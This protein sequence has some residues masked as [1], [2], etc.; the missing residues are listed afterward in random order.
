M[1]DESGALE[2]LDRRLAREEA[3]VR[4]VEKAFRGVVPAV[5]E[6]AEQDL[7]IRDVGDA[8][9]AGAAGSQDAPVAPN[10]GPGIDEVLENI[11]KDDAIGARPV[12]RQRLLRA[13]DE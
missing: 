13:S 11:R 3:Q 2:E 1:D 8:G 6:E 12:G 5:I 10:D 7:A 4:S 9:D